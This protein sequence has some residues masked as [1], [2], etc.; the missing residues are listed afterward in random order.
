V[1]EASAAAHVRRVIF[2][3]SGAIYGDCEEPKRECDQPAYSSAYGASKWL[4]E[5]MVGHYEDLSPVVFRYGNVYGPGQDPQGEAGVIAVWT[6]LLLAGQPVRLFGDGLQTRDYISVYDVA[7]ANLLALDGPAG[8]YNI[9]TGVS[10]SLVDVLELL[11]HEVGSPTVAHKAPLTP[12]DAR[13]VRLDVT[14]AREVLDF[15]ARISLAAGIAGYVDNQ[16]H[17]S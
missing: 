14:R 7:H 16:R 11:W 10:R 8:T 5:L 17:A 9:A 2:A 4:G 13:H 12:G 3:S 6:A 15:S 1:L